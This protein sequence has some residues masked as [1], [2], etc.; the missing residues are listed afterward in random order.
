M[1]DWSFVNPTTGRFAPGTSSLP[2]GVDPAGFAP[3][4]YVPMRGRFNHQ[5]ARL[6]TKTGHVETID[7]PRPPDDEMRTWR[8]DDATGDYVP[9]PT[10]AA[11]KAAAAAPLLAELQAEDA[12]AI[13][14]MAELVAALAAGELPADDAKA[15]LQQITDR[16]TVLRQALR[17]IEAADGEQMK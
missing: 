14:P 16:K 11:R 2:D 1:I 12:R 17:E 6:N 8:R 10:L 7:P 4:G 5:R 15:A 3:P 9:V 13:R